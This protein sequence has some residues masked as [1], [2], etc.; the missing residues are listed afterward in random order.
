MVSMKLSEFFEHLRDHPSVN[1]IGW[2]VKKAEP[3]K[4]YASGRLLKSLS[5]FPD[6]PRITC[7][8]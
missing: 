8:K 5:E 4:D 3:D 7:G 2:N 6:L 1:V